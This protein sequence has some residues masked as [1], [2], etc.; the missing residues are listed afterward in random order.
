MEGFVLEC[1]IFA[2][3]G[4]FGAFGVGLAGLEAEFDRFVLDAGV[5]GA[6]APTEAFVGAVFP[7][8]SE[9]VGS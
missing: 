4:A 9:V 7:A 5:V 3:A 2:A 1:G 6:D 8:S